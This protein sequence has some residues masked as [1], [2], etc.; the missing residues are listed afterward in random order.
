MLK[1]AIVVGA[2]SGIGEALSR[3]LVREGGKV[4]LV[5]RRKERLDELAAELN[6]N[7]QV[8]RAFGVC[9]DA[10]DTA[11]VRAAFDECVRRLDGLDLIIY[12]SGVMPT[13]GI[14][15]F[16]PVM[17]REIIETNVIGAMNW[18]DPAAERFSIQGAGTIVGIGSVAGDR[19][20]VGNPAY[21]ASKAALATY[22]EALRNRLSRKGVTVVTVKPGPV[23][24][25]MTKELTKLPM[26][27]EADWAADRILGA[28]R[29]GTPE[30]YVP[31]QWGP[32]MAVI[33]NIPSVVFRRLSV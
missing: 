31:A 6:R 21:C 20:R 2:S 26:V 8:E 27:V 11:T 33:R 5:A 16:D 19:G 25:P 17:D 29:S 28:I 14:D 7:Q 32:I 9:H 3:A 30:A 13:V 15:E 10:R 22:L 12:A 4:A 18:L 24:T 1:R 23:R